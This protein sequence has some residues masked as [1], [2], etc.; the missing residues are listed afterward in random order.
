MRIARRLAACVAALTICLMAVAAQAQVSVNVVCDPAD[1]NLS[2]SATGGSM[3]AF[4][5]KSASGALRPENVTAGALGGLFDVATPAK[6]F[7]LDPNGFAELNLGP[8]APAGLSDLSDLSFDGALVGGGGL[9]RDAPLNVTVVPEP[10]ALA[11][12]G[13][14]FV[15]LL[16]LRR[17]S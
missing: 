11:L 7:K 16:R 9:D 4:E 6:I 5:V 15:G 14:G 13:F 3:T 12:L 10:S 8:V 1:G 17:R 2:I